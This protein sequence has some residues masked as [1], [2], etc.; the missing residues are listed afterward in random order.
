MATIRMD[1]ESAKEIEQMGAETF[2]ARRVG[3]PIPLKKA[4]AE[5]E[6]RQRIKAAIDVA[7]A[8]LGAAIKHFQSTAAENRNQ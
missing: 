7:Y 1:G 4:I 5:G 2:N 3:G 6:A 8:D